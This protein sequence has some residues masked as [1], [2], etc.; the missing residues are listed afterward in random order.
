MSGYKIDN[1][2]VVKAGSLFIRLCDSKDFWHR[3]P[4]I[5]RNKVAPT[6]LCMV[7]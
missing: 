6:K 3:P 5:S 4:R 2:Y 1:A 7:R